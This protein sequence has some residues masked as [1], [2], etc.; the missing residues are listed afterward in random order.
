M[1]CKL[2]NF[3][4][5]HQFTHLI[6]TYI[7]VDTCYKTCSALLSTFVQKRILSLLRLCNQCTHIRLSNFVVHS[8]TDFVVV[9]VIAVELIMKKMFYLDALFCA[10]QFALLL[11]E[12]AVEVVAVLLFVQA[13]CSPSVLNVY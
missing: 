4:V 7:F 3:N 5:C 8:N 10:L 12:A 6:M 11:S 1:Y 13:T 2:I 9:L